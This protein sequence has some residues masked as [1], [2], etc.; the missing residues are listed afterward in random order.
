MSSVIRAADSW[1]IDSKPGRRP[2]RDWRRF[3]VRTIGYWLASACLLVLGLLALERLFGSE[4]TSAGERSSAAARPAVAVSDERLEL[5]SRLVLGALEGVRSD[6]AL[7]AGMSSLTA[8]VSDPDLTGRLALSHDLQTFVVSKSWCRRVALVRREGERV[9]AARAA[10]GSA[11]E[12]LA[13][14]APDLDSSQVLLDHAAAPDGSGTILCLALSL[15]TRHGSA[16]LVAEADPNLLFTALS[17][18]SP[19]GGSGP[20]LRDGG[21][22]WLVGP[23]PGTGALVGRAL[24]LPSWQ[25]PSSG[26]WE[27]AVGL[28]RAVDARPDRR[29]FAALLLAAGVAATTL[30]LVVERR[31]AMLAQL[32]TP[33]RR[34]TPQ[35]DRRDQA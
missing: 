15:G 13:A 24:V 35:P 7:V 29:W 10:D 17:A 9:A 2:R 32:D 31:R 16:A 5:A 34:V 21:E 25:G 20:F 30:A 8:Y 26:K 28:S 19:P 27:V 14:V 23:P 4:T 1:W 18:F 6:L 12:R 11:C 22:R 33:D 3:A